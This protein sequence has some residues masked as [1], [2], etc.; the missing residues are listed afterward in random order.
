MPIWPWSRFATRHTA[1]RLGSFGFAVV[2]LGHR[3]RKFLEAVQFSPQVHVAALVS[4]DEHKARRLAHAFAVPSFHPYAHFDRLADNPAVQAVYLSLPTALHREF[5]ERAA[6]AG[7]HV[8]CEKPL[9]ATPADGQAMIAACQSAQRLLM[10]G[11]RLALTA[12]HREARDRLVSGALGEITSIRSGF[13]FRAK[14]GWRLDP[15]LAGGGSLYDVGIYAVNAIHTLLNES[16]T[17]RTARLT[18]DPTTGLELAS[19]WRGSLATGSPIECR[20]SF[21][22]KIPDFFEVETSR[23]TL[24][25]KPAFA[26]QGLAL[27]I[28][29]RDPAHR[30]LN[31]RLTTPRTEPSAFRLEAE[32]L[33][34]CAQT[35]AALLTP[36]ELAVRDLQILAAIER[37]AAP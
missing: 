8:L 4:G 21:L 15:A 2:G 22:E 24:T 16:I 33:A 27:N 32:H 3:A 19:N 11:Y 5:T 20:S 28:Q 14:P 10:P 17:V 9:A 1:P 34:S 31:F 18:R 6:R 35:G 23:A 30:A 12:V 7:K 13:G 37:Q 25:L 36:P 26:Y 29:A